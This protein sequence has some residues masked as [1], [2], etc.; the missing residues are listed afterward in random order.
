ME[1]RPEV[2]AYVEKEKVFAPAWPRRSFRFCL[3]ACARRTPDP[4]P[5]PNPN[6]RSVRSPDAVHLLQTEL[7]LELE[8]DQV[9]KVVVVVIVLRYSGVSNVPYHAV[10]QSW[11]RGGSIAALCTV[12]L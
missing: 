5:N 10:P 12:L 6:H 7:E 11:V 9:R 4:N 1:A 8:I 3:G 2:R